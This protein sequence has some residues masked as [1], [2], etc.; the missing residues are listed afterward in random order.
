MEF[1]LDDSLVPG[2]EPVN[3]L[4]ELEEWAEKAV[5]PKPAKEPERKNANEKCPAIFD[6]ET[7]PLSE[8]KLRSIY[9]EKTFEEFAESCDQRWKD[10][11]KRAKYE[12]YKAN[13]WTQFVSKA[14][15]SPITGQVLAIGVKRGNDTA[16]FC[17]Q[18]GLQITGEDIERYILDS[19]WTYLEDLIA[20]K[21][22]I[23]GHNSNTFDLPFLVRRSWLLGVRVPREIRQGRYWNP[24]FQDTME[25][26]GCGQFAFVSLNELGRLF[27]CGQ[28]TEGVCGADFHKLWSGTMDGRGTPE[29]QRDLALEYLGQDLTLTQRIAEKL[30]MI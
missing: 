11:T 12:D 25:V 8:E 17:D 9:R 6:I 28:K 14:A 18:P 13:A 27:N 22:P 4:K 5:E 1:L 7:G 16:F 19:F 21:M 10:D 3:E 29:E 30:G 26:W 20:E 23:I 24:L 2:V 15:L